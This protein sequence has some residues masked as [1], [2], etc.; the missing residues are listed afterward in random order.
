[1]NRRGAGKALEKPGVNRM[2]ISHARGSAERSQ[3]NEQ[4]D[5]N[6][7]WNGI[8]IWLY[9]CFTI[10]HCFHLLGLRSTLKTLGVKDEDLQKIFTMVSPH[11]VAARS[12]REVIIVCK[13]CNDKSYK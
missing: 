3:R 10:T 2:F 1:M 11:L 4:A 13:K 9:F 6:K 7:D 5:A 8:S 12:G